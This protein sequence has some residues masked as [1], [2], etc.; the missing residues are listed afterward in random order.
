MIMIFYYLYSKKSSNVN[1][2]Q[3]G[4]NKTKQKV[5]GVPRKCVVESLFIIRHAQRS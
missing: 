1:H 4:G 2:R 3:T 5:K